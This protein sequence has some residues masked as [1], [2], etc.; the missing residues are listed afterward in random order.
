MTSAL[1]GGRGRQGQGLAGR[2]G[3]RGVAQDVA[4]VDVVHARRRCRRP[5]WW[6]ATGRR[7]SGRRPRSRAAT[8]APL[9][10]GARRAR[11]PAHELGRVREG[12]AHEH[13]RD[14][15]VV[16][17]DRLFARELKAT[18]AL[19][20]T[21]GTKGVVV[22]AGP[23]RAARAAHQ[24]RGGLVE[25]AQEDVARPR[26]RRRPTGCRPSDPKATKRPDGEMSALPESALPR[27]PAT[28]VAR[29]TS[30]L[31]AAARSRTKT[32]ADGVVV[33]GGEVVGA[34]VEGDP[35]AV[36]RDRRAKESSFAP[37]PAGP[38]RAAH[39]G[40]RVGDQVAHEDVAERVVCRPSTGCWR[41]TRRRRS[42]RRPRWRG[43]RSSRRSPPAPLGARARGS[44]GSSCR[45]PGRARR[46]SG[47]PLSSSAERLSASDSNATK[48]PSAEIAGSDESSF[49]RGAAPGPDARLDER[50]RVRRRRPGRR[51][52]RRGVVVLGR[53]VVR[54][55]VEGDLR[56]A[57]RD[58]GRSGVAVD[59]RA[60]RAAGARDQDQVVL[61]REGGRRQHGRGHGARAPRRP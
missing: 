42:A 50:R 55:G 45:R 33:L 16:R 56:A 10:G 19:S 49:R 3:D 39:E 18:R 23:A 40:R 29:L 2:G 53:E 1:S 24:R 6:R 31:V 38:G 14:G 11:R 60:R 17:A 28:P 35:V 54:L 57:R 59:G 21:T 32:F 37:A 13:V 4:A 26:C 48:R 12:V 36:A 34:R 5:G 44:R 8:E 61:G 47:T 43:P 46:C 20:E 25:V 58:R 27:A 30:A 15:V 22:R 7:R 52:S 51:R 41:P 9:A